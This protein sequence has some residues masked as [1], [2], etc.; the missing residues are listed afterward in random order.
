V[1]TGLRRSVLVCVAAVLAVGV[2]GA[3]SAH[4]ATPVSRGMH[5]DPLAT[6]AGAAGQYGLFSCQVGAPFASPAGSA[7]YD[8]F[9]MRT[10]YGV[11]SLIAGGDDGT[12]KTIVILDAFQNPNLVSQV[13]FYNNFYG[14]PATNL[15]Q[16][17]P[18]GLTPF[19]PGDPNMTGWAEEISL[20]VE[21]A[22]NIAPGANIVLDLAKDNSDEALLSAF[23]YAVDNNLG[24]VISMS[25]GE[26]ESCAPTADWHQAFV[27]AT[28]K[29]ITLFA[30]SGDQ[31][32][33]QPTCD[34][35][36]WIKSASAP[37]SD[38]LVTAVGGTTLNAASFCLAQL[39][40]CDPA[41]AP[42]AGTYLGE[43]GWNEGPLGDFPAFFSATEASGGGFSTIWSEPSYQQ[44]TIHGG[45]TRAEPD[46]AYNGAILHGVLT[47]LNIPG[48]PAG[49]YR[50][51]GTSCGAPQWSAL[52]AIADQAAGHDYGFINAAL[53]KLG[54]NASTYSGAFHDV[55]TGNNS[56][57][58]FDS[59]NNPVNITGF[60]AGTGWDAVTGLGSPKAGGLLSELPSVW[61]AGQGTAAI[62]NSRSG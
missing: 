59:S 7:C 14:L 51:G 56:A 22:H 32:A 58:E 16:V 29:G 36:S 5:V 3:A 54:Q 41:S 15:T 1:S 52:T 48:I 61:S 10:A 28:K 4:A 46:V 55:T 17:A 39:H 9:Q 49:F 11:D 38:P 12:G 44:G 47:Y 20:D 8:P 6:P 62:Q 18:D 45:K 57:L 13:A 33:A 42:A 24:D 40:N 23:N 19:V 34:G 26:A 35:N 31:G 21:W 53:Y 43:T 27:N 2:F 37:A 30:S 60:D 50:F 25:F